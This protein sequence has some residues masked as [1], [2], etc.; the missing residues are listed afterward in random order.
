MQ[1]S[2]KAI[3]VKYAVD[4]LPEHFGPGARRMFGYAPR[5]EKWLRFKENAKRFGRVIGGR[6]VIGGRDDDLVFT[7]RL[8]DQVLLSARFNI[9]A[10]PSR[11]TI[12]MSGP[13]Y[14]T[15]RP[16][17]KGTARLAREVLAMS[18]RHERLLGDAGDRGFNEELRRVRQERRLR[19]VSRQG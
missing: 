2:H 13:V 12:R 4:L 3:G 8:R 9:Q 5:T 1:A 18:S 15:L 10:Y 11:V 17:G 19:K 6:Q 7:G 16:R 14:F